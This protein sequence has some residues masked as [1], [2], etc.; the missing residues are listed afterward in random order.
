M[1]FDA[2]VAAQPE[3][4]ARSA[5]TVREALKGV[6]LERWRNG[7]LATVAIGA[8]SHASHAFVARLVRAGR[9]SVALDAAELFSGGTRHVADSFVFVS[10]GGRSRETLEGVAATAGSPRLG[11]TNDL[12]APLADQV[13]DVVDLGHGPDSPVYTV[14]YTATLQAFGLLATELDDRDEGDDWDALPEL[15]ERTLTALR[16]QTARAAAALTGVSSVDVVAAAA[17]RASAGEG[18]LLIREA[19]RTPAAPWETYQYLHG[20]MESL[21]PDTGCLV[22]GEDR[23]IE[24]ARYVAGTGAPTVLVTTRAVEEEAGMTVVRIPSAPVLTRTILQALP[25]QLIV[26]ELAGSRGLGIG[27][28]RYHQEDTK[29]PASDAS[30]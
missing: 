20:P 24:L 14:G 11:L 4:L 18:A 23:E 17:S 15:V 8:S 2:A 13:D 5:A 25:L 12:G 3:R 19:T 6:R 26:G 22:V 28:F 16:D 29:V 30:A 9:R 10:E 27:T 1:E 21:G 7:A